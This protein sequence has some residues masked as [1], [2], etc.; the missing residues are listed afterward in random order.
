MAQLYHNIYI[1]TLPVTLHVDSHY[2]NVDYF[3]YVRIS[4][5]GT[6]QKFSE[7]FILDQT[8]I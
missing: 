5:E 1:R 6:G 3:I 2:I 4:L 8:K 7:N